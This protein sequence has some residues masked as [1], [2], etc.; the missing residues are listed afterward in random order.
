MDSDRWKQVDNLLHAALERPPAERAEF[1]RQVCAG[2][3]ELEREVQ[4]LLASDRQAGSFLDSPAME[5]A[6]RSI[7]D[8]Q[9]NDAPETAGSLTGQ[10]MSHY[11]ILE[12]LGGGGMGVVYK[13]EDIRLHRF[14]ALKF[15][16]DEIAHD[17]QA[18]SRFEREARAASALN[19]A[20]ICTVHDIGAQDG[21]S[22][23]VMESL[24]GT[25]LKHR[26]G[27]RPLEIET[28]LPLAI[29]IADGLDA[30]HGAGIVHRDIKPANIFVTTRGNAKILDFGLAKVAPVPG[31]TA[32]STL[33]IEDELTSPGSALGTVSYMSPEQVRAKPLDSRTD[34]FSFGV[35]LYEMAT[36]KLPFRGESSGVIFEAILNSAPVPPVR[37]NPDLPA[38]L[39]HIIDKC[40]EKDR[41]LRYQHAAD[42]RTDLQRL[43]RDTDSGRVAAATSVP[44]RW[45]LM[46]P[47]AAA[48]L[49]IVAA[50]YL[51]FHR[52]PKLT[53]RDTIVLADFTNTTGD[54]IFDGTLR[55]GL[56]IQLEQS[57][58]L[59]IMED[60]Q[61][62]GVLRL[63]SLPPG[64]RVTNPIAHEICVREGA[65]ATIDGT[66]ASL[67]K[68][69]VITLQ[70]ITCQAGATL[71][72]EQIQAGDK[73]HVLNALGTAAAA[74]RAK[75]GESLNSIEKLNRPLEQAT[76]PSLEALQN[77][78]AGYSEME[79]SQSEAAIASFE[80]AIAIDPNFAMGYYLLAVAYENAGDMA[81]S[82]D[83][84]KQAFRLVGRVSEYE[85][86]QIAPYYYRATGE[87]YKEIDAWQ[88]SIR[89]LPRRWEFHN[90]LGLI[91]VDL[92]RYEEG[93]KE[94]LEATGL[95]AN[96]EP[97]Y[98]RQLDAYICLDRLP[99]ARQLAQKLREQG[100]DGPRIHQRFLEM[101]YVEG[102]DAVAAREIQ[103]F[104]GKPEEY[105][106]LGLQAANRNVHGQRGESH[107]LFQQAEESA[108]RRG[109]R[110]AA[111]E[112]EEADARADALSGD[113][114]TGR[115]LGR[116]AL[117]L[118]MC[119]DAAQAEKLAAE[120]SKVFP[121]GTI[122]NSVQLP[123]IRATI[124]LNRGEPA[125]AVELLATASPYE[126]S[127]I[128]ASYVRGLAYLRLHKG[129]EAAAEFHK[130]LDH[131]G[132]S[133]GATWVHPYW[134]QY[135]ALSYLGLAR[136]SALAGDTAK[137]G[138]AYQ[139]FLTLWKDADPDIPVLKQAK[140]EYAK[141]Q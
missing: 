60:G 56:A 101:A 114:R 93:L 78:T 129:A 99:E 18:H 16:P 107:K 37:L 63:M 118:A 87:V 86:A 49:A 83:Y 75:L 127:Y 122:W 38:E 4:S 92:G 100:L 84:A 109:L 98:R 3:Q 32:G 52:K 64:A 128:E 23:I 6:A 34:I 106:S 5:L 50:G 138:R 110:D 123:E 88:L 53:D 117:A 13:A 119:G 140:T 15:L 66:I 65:A 104:A 108:L 115:R 133:W 71:A 141:L 2:D 85:R 47:A 10:T 7:A 96:I 29:E 12:K 28:L 8:G 55:Q 70:A 30:A 58:F 24:D 20:N 135:Y 103:W 25:T 111:S 39:E 1:L 132:A 11:R 57:P 89:N 22:F 21:R 27:T 36:G 91:Y 77:Y 19:H 80:R 73:E 105:I 69:Y 134:G 76:T 54:P 72:R 94:G 81:R 68:N 51:Y 130:I 17:P 40:L 126:R 26:I 33:T 43:K 82:R 120:T 95:Q 97:P 136:A 46:V 35:V 42:I 44:K 74:M 121:N 124:A 48:V 14:V 131:K 125:K 9:N 67:G 62:Q 61:V 116:P 79:K 45:K 139:D 90:Q 59:K 102:D 113:C 112:F 137:A 31:N 41:N